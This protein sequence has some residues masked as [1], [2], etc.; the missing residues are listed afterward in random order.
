MK[1]KKTNPKI[2]E[3]FRGGGSGKTPS[4]ILDWCIDITNNKNEINRIIRNCDNAFANPVAKRSIYSD[5]LMKIHQNGIFIYAHDDCDIGY[6]ALYANDLETKQG[7]ISLIAVKPEYQKMHIGKN[8]L[9]NALDICRK[10]GM[11]SCVLEVKKNN[12]SAQKFYLANNFVFLMEQDDSF[13]MRCELYPEKGKKDEYQ[14]KKSNITCN[15]ETG[16]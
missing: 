14:R 11:L 16:L 9:D 5:L 6:C 2:L 7:Y 4:I 1:H 13:L 12:M 3:N 8:I 10:N 15:G